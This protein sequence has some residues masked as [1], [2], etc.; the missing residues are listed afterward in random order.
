MPENRISADYNV[1]LDICGAAAHR[2]FTGKVLAECGY[3]WADNVYL[4]HISVFAG[5]ELA[6]KKNHTG[7]LWSVGL[8]GSLQF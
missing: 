3:M 5:A 4:P 1:A 6:G 7:N 2:I 8:Q